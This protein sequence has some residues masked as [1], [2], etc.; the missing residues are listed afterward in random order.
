MGLSKYIRA[1]AAAAV[2]LLACQDAGAA[3]LSGDK[4]GMVLMHGKGGNTKLVDAL[5]DALRD[6]GVVVET[7]LMA[8]SKDRIYDRTYDAAMEDID[9]AVARLKAAGARRIVIGGHSMGAN[10]AL[11]YAARRGGLAGV[12]LLAYGHY[13]SGKF[14][15]KTLAS[16]V[17]RAK[18]M[19]DAGNGGQ[20][21][22][23]S[24]INQGGL[25]ARVVRADIYYSWFAPDG[26]ASDQINAA[27]VKPGTPV[28]WVSGDRDR[29]SR[30]GKSLIW[31]RIA[32]H[33]KN[34]F[35]VISSNHRGTPLD[36]IET[37]TD[38]LRTL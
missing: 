34:K 21:A 20:T 12:V 23:F 10:A 13:P 35:Q 11:G 29:P 22:S 38:W 14:F 8:W 2:L 19:I 24:D 17:A 16:D 6:A 28:L 1:F 37:V 26:P 7:P 9:A 33:P 30:Q 36:S 3:P 18:A 31:S 27:R 25:Q 5:A 4:I 32:G 15:R